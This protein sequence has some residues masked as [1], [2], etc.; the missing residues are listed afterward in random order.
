MRNFLFDLENDTIVRPSHRIATLRAEIRILGFVHN[1]LSA[2]EFFDNEVVG[3]SLADQGRKVSH[4]THILGC[5]P[6]QVN[7]ERIASC[8]WILMGITQAKKSIL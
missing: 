6:R 5:G 3:D 4:Q 1:A 8:K 2:A 7:E